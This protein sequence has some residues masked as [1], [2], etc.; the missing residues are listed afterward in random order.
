MTLLQVT[1]EWGGFPGA[2]GYTNLHYTNAG[3]ITSAVD[4]AVEASRKLFDDHK[5][6]YASNETFTVSNEVKEFDIVTG[7]LIGLHSPGTPAAVVTGSGSAS[8][9]PGPAGACV[10][11]GTDGVNRG[12]RVRGRVFLVPIAVGWFQNDGTLVPATIPLIEGAFTTWRTSAAYETLV[13]SRPRLGAGGAAFP[14]LSSTVR[15][16]VAVL[17]S[18]RD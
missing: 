18:R 15:D 8:M 3:I 7:A 11:L 13:W 4:N 2:P 17:R 9:G 16:R 6:L 12:R 10:S 14:I 1:V 5:S